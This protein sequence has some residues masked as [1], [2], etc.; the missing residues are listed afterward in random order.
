MSTVD[1]GELVVRI[2]GDVRKLVDGQKQA[3]DA[4]EKIDKKSAAV[5]A[6]VQR[7]ADA[8]AKSVIAV[9]IAV[10]GFLFNR[11]VQAADSLNKLSAQ[12]GVSAT[13]L[14]ELKFVAEHV[15]VE[16]GAVEQ[17]VRGW[18]AT[19]VE[20]SQNTRTNASMALRTLGVDIKDA[21]G[22]VR[23]FD[24]VLGL[25]S[26]ALSKYADGQNKA[27]LA[28]AIFKEGGAALIPLLNQSAKG[29]Q[30]VGERGK[31]LGAI[32]SAEGS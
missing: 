11:A 7:N 17:A 1:I 23:P 31:A 28:T 18:N 30:E 13:A 2:S 25:V 22:N 21:V 10:A 20:M 27:A 12:T 19:L 9:G 26:D 3:T 8:M 14:S 15:G 24:E 5:A 29:I 6:N 4:L 32:Q 16:F